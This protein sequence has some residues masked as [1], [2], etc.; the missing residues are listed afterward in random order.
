VEGRLTDG[1]NEFTLLDH[2]MKGFA[3]AVTGVGPARLI[4][5]ATSLGYLTPVAFAAACLA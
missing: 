1:T 2:P 4:D 5:G 3:G